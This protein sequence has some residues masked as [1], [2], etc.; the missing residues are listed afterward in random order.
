MSFKDI[1]GVYKDAKDQY[2]VNIPL[3]ERVW[4]NESKSGE[5]VVTIDIGDD[6]LDCI[7]SDRQ[8]ALEFMSEFTG[9]I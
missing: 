8:E 2:F 5:W 6:N 9:E 3:V 4:I 7:F 1:S